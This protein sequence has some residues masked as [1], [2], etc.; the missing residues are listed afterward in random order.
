M[1]PSFAFFLGLAFVSAALGFWLLSGTPAIICQIL[2]A[3]L[4]IIAA[5]GFL[6]RRKLRK[7]LQSSFA[8]S[9]PAETPA[10]TTCSPVSRLE[11]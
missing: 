7:S 9:F 8:A 3:P 5:L 4:A 6:S 2:S 1:K 11:P 10:A